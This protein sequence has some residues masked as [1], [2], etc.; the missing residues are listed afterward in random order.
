MKKILIWAALIVAVMIAAKQQ[1]HMATIKEAALDAWNWAQ[2]H[3]K[4]VTDYEPKLFY[5]NLEEHRLTLTTREQ[6]YVRNISKS[7][8]DLLIF[9][10]RY[11]LEEEISHL[12]LDD[13]NLLAVCQ[14][15]QHTLLLE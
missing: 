1:Q 14:T 4:G 2:S 9:Y 5:K 3:I 7:S 10:K 13:V 15:T 6:R 12:V 8:S 11:C